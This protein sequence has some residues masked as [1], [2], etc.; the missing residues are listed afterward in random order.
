MANQPPDDI[1]ILVHVTAPSRAVDDVAY[2]QLA[3]AYLGFQAQTHSNI[4]LTDAQTRRRDDGQRKQASKQTPMLSSELPTSAPVQAFEI[5]SQD[6]SFRS[7]LDNRSSPRLRYTAARNAAFPSSQE[8]G[9]GSQ[10]S[11]CPPSSEIS[12]SYPMPEAGLLQV[13]PSRVLRHYIGRPTREQGS[14]SSPSPTRKRSLPTSSNPDQA[15]VPSSLPA[16]VDEAGLTHTP[17]YIQKRQTILVTPPTTS[18]T[19]QTL[20]KAQKAPR[21]EGQDAVGDIPVNITHISSSGVSNQPTAASPRAESEPPSAKRV[22]VNQLQHGDLVRSSSDTGPIL[23]SINST[24][25]IFSSTLEIRP[26]SPPVGV[27][28]ID[29]DGMVP[30]KFAKLASDLSSRYRP[31]A[32]RDVDP[33][34]R[35]YWLLDC[36]TWSPDARFGA[37]VFLNNYLRSGLAGWGTWC[38]R[39]QT[40][41][42]IRLYCW[43]HV[44]KHT[45]LL[46][47]LASERH[48]KTTGAGWYD[49]EGQLVLEVLPHEK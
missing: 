32:K 14:Q 22:K 35:G 47:Y 6:I 42:W 11:W 1:E 37:W 38:R 13:S 5:N 3:Q 46:L 44:A 33:F 26:P 39:D 7:A 2:R 16:T 30:P 41:D 12:D 49:A 34:E 24:L 25:D 15:D 9:V 31:E 27:S 8:S 43:G 18:G 10:T 29:P 21:A 19:A 28:D 20:G 23:S 36:S 48:L 40:H 45:Y 4:Q 17:G